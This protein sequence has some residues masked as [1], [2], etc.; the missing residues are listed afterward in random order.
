LKLYIAHK[1]LPILNKKSLFILT[2]PFLKESNWCLDA[3]EFQKCNLLQEIFQYELDIN[4]ADL[5]LI[6]FPIN[7]YFN[8]KQ[9]HLLEEI[10][11]LCA[12]NKIKAYA[13]VSDDFGNKYPEFSNIVY[14]RMGGFKTKLSDKNKGFPVALS[15]HFQRLFHKEIITPT[16]KS[17]LPIIGFCG[18]ATTTLSKRLKELAKCVLENGKRFFKNP[19]NKNYE[20][21]F[22]SA[23]ER[24]VLLNYFKISGLVKTN[25]IFREHYRGGAVTN[26]EREKT[27]LEYYQNILESD[28]VLCVRGAGNFSVR[29][30]ETLMLGKIPI[31]VNTDCLLPF[32]KRINWKKHVVWVE[33]NE[34][35]N[36][37]AI[38]AHFHKNRSNEDFLQLQIE[39]RKLWK[40]TLSV[41]GMLQLLENNQKR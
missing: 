10:N 31:F 27:T 18:H 29:L 24:A 32:E 21:L 5:V 2:R 15:D 26:E 39:N 37:A 11:I 28:Y 23:Y 12:A 4:N 19:L 9:S 30:Y 16:P 35:K 33:W 34:R 13:Y 6:P 38:V 1:N 36:V 17:K 14:F 8:T 20:P 3:N 7:F 40:E 25:F 22:A 41:E